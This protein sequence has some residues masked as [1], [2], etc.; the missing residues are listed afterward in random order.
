MPLF[1]HAVSRDVHYAWLIHAIV[2]KANSK[3]A[4]IDHFLHFAI[5][6]L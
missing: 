4:D 3:I 2:L 1:I 6:F 5:T